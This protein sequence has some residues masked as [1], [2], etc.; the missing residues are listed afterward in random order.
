M[1]EIIRGSNVYWFLSQKEFV[2][3]RYTSFWTLSANLLSFSK[4]ILKESNVKGGG[5]LYKQ[6]NPVII[7]A[8]QCC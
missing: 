8:L 5:S 7:E 6:L 3:T 1:V 2:D 4:N